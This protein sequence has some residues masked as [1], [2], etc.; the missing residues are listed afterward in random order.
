MYNI[1]LVDDEENVRCSIKNLT[2]WNEHGFN[3]P[4]VASNGREALDM[5]EDNIPDVIITDI[6]MGL[7]QNVRHIAGA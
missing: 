4:S 1:L 6:K 3:V 2:P 7:L 5:M